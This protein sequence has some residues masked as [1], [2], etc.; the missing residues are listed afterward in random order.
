MGILRWTPTRWFGE[1]PITRRREHF[2]LHWTSPTLPWCRGVCSNVGGVHVTI[3]NVEHIL[4]CFFA[5]D[6]LLRYAA[7][8]RKRLREPSRT[9]E[10][11]LVVKRSFPCFLRCLCLR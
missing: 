3:R 8:A 11:L 10:V 9:T 2:Y 7:A 6:V 1:W 4:V 5:A